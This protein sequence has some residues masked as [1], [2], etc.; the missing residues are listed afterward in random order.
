[1]TSTVSCSSQIVLV[2]H[3]GGE[4]MGLAEGVEGMKASFSSLKSSPRDLWVIFI[5]KFIE[6]L[7]LQNPAGSTISLRRFTLTISAPWCSL[8]YFSKSI[9]FTILLS[10]PIPKGFALSDSEVSSP[11]YQSLAHPTFCRGKKGGRER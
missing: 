5:I 8:A 11:P 1:M 9:V 3:P 4:T 6:R 2:H 7:T 10:D